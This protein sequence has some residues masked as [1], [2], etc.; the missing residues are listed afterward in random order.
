MTEAARIS[1]PNFS[2]LRNA[3]FYRNHGLNKSVRL[4]CMANFLSYITNKANIKVEFSHAP[5][6]DGKTIWLG[7]IDVEDVDYEVIVLGHGIHEVMHVLE[8]DMSYVQR[9]EE[10]SFAKLLLNVLE[11]V[12]IDLLGQKR[13]GGY[14]TWRNELIKVLKRRRSLRVAT[15]TARLDPADLLGM[16]LHTKLMVQAGFVWAQEY[17]PELQSSVQKNLSKKTVNKILQISHEV[18]KAKSTKDVVDI[19]ERIVGYLQAEHKTLTAY[20]PSLWNTEEFDDGFGIDTS[21][22]LAANFMRTVIQSNCEGIEF[23][24]PS[25]RLVPETKTVKDRLVRVDES[26]AYWPDVTDHKLLN[27]DAKYY[28][29]YFKK[30][31]GLV[32]D[33]SR[34]L[35]ELLETDSDNGF[36]RARSGHDISREWY[37][38]TLSHD[39]RIFERHMQNTS[40]STEVCILLD[41][42]GSMG[43]K[44]M[45]MAK[46][47]VLGIIDTLKK[48]DGCQVR[49][50]CF[51]GP[52]KSHVSIVASP[53]ESFDSIDNRFRKIGA[54]GSTPVEEALRWGKDSFAGTSDARDRLLLVITDGRFPS[55]FSRKVE[56]ELNDQGVEIAL[57]SIGIANQN[58]CSNSHHINN[59][60]QIQPALISLFSNTRFH[61]NRLER[62]C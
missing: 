60:D 8:T 19:V 4:E 39:E 41:R 28:S 54:Y 13:F 52:I 9:F 46:A 51:P 21:A 11:D 2:E 12:R 7:N 42:S 32:G 44:A 22:A 5:C 18:F 20:Q 16:F 50:A 17:L 57:L 27:E 53:N 48:I 59:I 6:T 49:A 35:E 10:K 62:Y 26:D 36:I 61:R 23:D 58:A 37:E 38:R 29:Q 31:E 55:E 30:I 1:R 25:D 40:V 47:A 56:K 45:S 34:Q 33:M 24:V 3:P 14:K 15:D 43:V